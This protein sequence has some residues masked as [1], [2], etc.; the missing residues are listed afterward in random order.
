MKTQLAKLPQNKSD[1]PSAREDD[2]EYVDTVVI[3][4]ELGVHPI[5]LAKWRLQK[6]GPPVTWIGRKA[7]Y[8]RGSARAW[9][10]RQEVVFD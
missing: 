8:R 10:R 2:D 7:R 1:E 4:D 3:A 5:T 9:Q 6:K